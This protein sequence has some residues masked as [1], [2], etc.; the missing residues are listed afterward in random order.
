MKLQNE[1]QHS[2]QNH[3]IMNTTESTR[4]EDTITDTKRTLQS[5]ASWIS[6]NYCTDIDIAKE[7]DKSSIDPE[8]MVSYLNFLEA[9]VAA[10]RKT[11]TFWDAYNI[12]TSAS[13]KEDFIQKYA[14]LPTNSALIIGFNSAITIGDNTYNRGDIVVKNKDNQQLLIKNAETGYY[15]PVSADK[16]ETGNTIKLTFKY[17]DGTAGQAQTIEVPIASTDDGILYNTILTLDADAKGSVTLKSDSSGNLIQPVFYVYESTDVGK[18][19][20]RLFEA[21]KIEYSD[22]TV[23]FTNLT[24]RQIYVVVR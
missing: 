11:A 19:G 18:L 1:Y 22:T 9:K 6:H 20:Q 4:V 15:M 16:E 24:D 2:L 3:V 21:I 10:A 14:Q 23:T 7:N 8:K 17:Q 5:I 12:T 13:D